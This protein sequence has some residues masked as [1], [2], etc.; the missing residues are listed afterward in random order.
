[1]LSIGLMS[2]TSMDGIDAALLGVDGDY[3]TIKDLGHVSLSYDAETKMLLKGAEY[4]IRQAKGNMVVAHHHFSTDLFTYITHEI[5]LPDPTKVINALMHYL[6]GTEQVIAL[7]DVIQLSTHLHIECVKRLLVQTGCSVSQIAII[8]YH[9]QTVYHQPSACLS[10]SLGNPQHMANELGV[11]VVHDF[12]RQDVEAGGQGAPFAPLYHHAIA[13][14]D[15]IVPVGVIN[16]GGISNVTL[17]QS[18]DEFDLISYDSGPGNALIDLFVRKKTMGAE[19]MDMDGAY[20]RKGKPHKTTLDALRAKALLKN[21]INYLNVPPPKALDIGDIMLIPE[22]MDLSINDGC[23][24]LEVFT[25]QT[26]VQSLALIQ[27]HHTCTTLLPQRWI[28]CGGGWKNPVIKYNF[29]EELKIYLSGKL[30]VETADE[31][32]WNSI[33]MEAQIFAYLAVRSLSRQPLS[34][35]NTT[36]VSKPMPGGMHY[37]PNNRRN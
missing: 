36:G 16:C 22:V 33:A 2:G 24:T 20:G 29:E 19:C 13:Q 31:A 37:Q 18:K 34:L 23:A 25:A 11:T 35:P 8:G 3:D 15:R 26:I 21:G 28:L 30:S 4:S 1:M 27:H 9:G 5:Q 7:H 6:Y 10:I 14:R 32:G 12:R 17:I